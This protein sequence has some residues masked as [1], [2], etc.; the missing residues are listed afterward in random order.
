[1]DSGL[2]VLRGLSRSVVGTFLI[3]ALVAVP[4]VPPAAAGEGEVLHVGETTTLHLEGQPWVFDGA[5]S[6]QARLVSVKNLGASA[7]KQRFQVKGL[8]AGQVTLVFR[9]GSKTFQAHIDVLN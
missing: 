3:A 1:M 7:S 8:K 2:R 5:A 4:V 6:R 9:S